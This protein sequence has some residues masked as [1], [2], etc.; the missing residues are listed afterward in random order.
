M[1]GLIKFLQFLFGSIFILAGFANI[2][3]CS[4]LEQLSDVEKEAWLHV[5]SVIQGV[6]LPIFLWCVAVILYC[7]AFREES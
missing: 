7:A 6:I 2:Y 5:P 1:K 3:L 4:Y